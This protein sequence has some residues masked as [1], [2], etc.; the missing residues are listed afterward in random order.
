VK[1]IYGLPARLFAYLSAVVFGGAAAVGIS[2]ALISIDPPSWTRGSEL[3]V[4]FGLAF[5]SDLRP[6]PMD[7]NR[8]DEVSVANIFIVTAAILFGVR[9]AIPMA[10][11]SIG[12][13]QIINRRTLWYRTGF[14]ASMYALATGAVGLPQLL[15]KIPTNPGPR[16]SAL[17][18]MGGAAH[19]LVNVVLI[20][21]VLTFAEK[22]PFH[23]VI[24]P[25]LRNGGAA[26]TITVVFAALAANLWQVDPVLLV[27]LAGPLFTM[28]LYQRTALKS[29][30]AARE[31]ETDSLTKLG[32]HRAYQAALREHVAW[33]DKAKTPFALCLLDV[34]NFKSLNDAFGH[35]V[36]DEVLVRLSALLDELEP[37]QAFRFGGDE[38]AVLVRLDDV[39]AYQLFEQVQAALI[40]SEICPGRPVTISTGIAAYPQHAVEVEELQRLADAALYW[41]KGHGK[42]RSCLYTPSVVRVYSHDELQ[43]AAERTALLQA[44]KNLVRFV[45]AKDRSTGNH[46]QIV[47]TLAGLIAVELGL[48]DGVVEQLRLAGLLHDLGKIGVPDSI[49]K[50]PRALTDDEFQIIKKHPEIGYSML[51]GLDLEP[52]NEWVL[53]HHEHWDGSGYPDGLSGESIPLGARIVLVADAFEAMTADRP[54]RRASSQDA[55]LEELR[56][57]AGRQFYPEAV[58][59]LERALADSALSLL[60]AT[61]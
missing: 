53:H 28:T 19:L 13:A 2:A 27:L 55:A 43:L 60:E 54:Y 5:V 12:A 61:A 58:V 21:F 23:Q 48:E 35:P 6:V 14:N 18:L 51:K 40:G 24:V 50:A 15:W 20:A 57:K 16:L 41:S 11:L 8:N 4:F 52:V 34:D 7:A 42:N 32:N 3:L 22:K 26:F 9:Y 45:D 56:A 29:R 44:A 37:A 36:G 47:S 39:G 49:L 17:V 25:G 10:A 31:A 46:S 38:F 59:A 33:S 1:T 30:V